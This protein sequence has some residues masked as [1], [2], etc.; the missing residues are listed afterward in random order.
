MAVLQ[1]RLSASISNSKIH[2]TKYHLYVSIVTELLYIHRLKSVVL[3]Q[4]R[5]KV[6]ITTKPQQTCFFVVTQGSRLLTYSSLKLSAKCTPSVRNDW[7]YF[8]G[9]ILYTRLNAW[10]KVLSEAYPTNSLIRLMLFSCSRKYR[11]A[12]RSR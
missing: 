1:L 12:R 7:R 8:R 9:D 4:R 11:A 5:I 3:R 10:L 6:A 2:R